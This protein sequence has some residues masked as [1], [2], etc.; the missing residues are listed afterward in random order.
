MSSP[1]GGSTHTTTTIFSG[2][3]LLGEDVADVQVESEHES[4]SIPDE[5]RYLAENYQGGK[6]IM[7]DIEDYSEDYINENDME[8]R[9]ANRSRRLIE[10][11]TP[12]TWKGYTKGIEIVS[13]SGD[14]IVLSCDLARVEYTRFRI[15]GIRIPWQGGQSLFDFYTSRYG[16]NADSLDN[17]CPPGYPPNN[18]GYS[19]IVPY[20]MKPLYSSMQN[21]YQQAPLFYPILYDWETRYEEICRALFTFYLPIAHKPRDKDGLIV[22]ILRAPKGYKIP[23]DFISFQDSS[24]CV[25]ANP[26]D[27]CGLFTRKIQIL[28]QLERRIE[29]ALPGLS[30]MPVGREHRV[31]LTVTT[32]DGGASLAPDVSPESLWVLELNDITSMAKGYISGIYGAPEDF[33]LNDTVNFSAYA[34]DSPPETV[35]PID[36]NFVDGGEKSPT[37]VQLFAP[38]GYTFLPACKAPEQDRKEVDKLFLSCKERYSL[39]GITYLSGAVMPM[40]GAGLTPAETP[41]SIKLLAQTPAET[42]RRNRWFSR[43]RVQQGPTAWGLDESPF[44]VRQMEASVNLLAIGGSTVS[45][46][47][48]VAFGYNLPWGGYV[49]LAAPKTYEL[50]CPIE[51]VLS[52][53]GDSGVE[54]ECLDDDPLL[55]GC[56]GLPPVNDTSGKGPPIPGCNPKHEILLRFPPPTT[57]V[58][59]TAFPLTTEVPEW[60]RLGIITTLGPETTTTT[61]DLGPKYAIPKGSSLLAAF[62]TKVPQV[63]PTPFTENRFRI[64]VLDASKISIDGKLNENGPEVRHAPVVDDFSLWWTKAVPNTVATVVLKFNWDNKRGP[65]QTVVTNVD[66]VVPEGFTMNVRRPTDIKPLRN[67]VPISNWS[68]SPLLPRH[69]WFFLDLEQNQNFTGTFYFSFPV[70]LPTKEKGVPVANLWQIKLCGDA[71]YCTQMVI[72]AFIPG[73]FFGEKPDFEL[74]SDILNMLTG[75]YGER[76]EPFMCFI[77][78]LAMWSVWVHLRLPA[79]IGWS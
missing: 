42:P 6:Y 29:I 1:F 50:S 79:H 28:K 59:T 31:T 51:K 49:H 9:P 56:W 5:E 23:Q 30:E 71:P 40:G 39:F 14:T 76:A 13:R 46:F 57:T 12:Y 54:P 16:I 26:D 67:T 33:I 18:P 10:W 21:K 55:Q 43:A 17:C 75:S 60:M 61:E 3:R 11:V 34:P 58:T 53:T 62:Q 74:P 52:L 70:L 44:P 72:T 73:F 4:L 27:T 2:G 45:L 63:T 47:L 38:F 64:K 69:A 35:V 48:A 68:W 66:V 78:G 7:D 20:R 22:L 15:S 65:N 8:S 36:F 37:T 41:V 32:P 77:V 25:K 19:F 24:A